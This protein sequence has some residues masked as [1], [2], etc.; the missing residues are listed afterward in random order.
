MKLISEIT[1][2]SIS[3]EILSEGTAPKKYKISGPFVH[4]EEINRNGRVYKKE[5]VQPEIDRYIREYVSARRALGELSHPDSPA[6]NP[7]ETSHL[8]TKLEF[9]DHLCMGEA[10]I[11]DTPNGKIIKSFIDGGVNFGVSTRG[12]GS[13]KESNGVKYVQSDFKLITVDVV[14]DPSG[15]DCYVEGMMEGKEWVYIEGHGWVE[16]YLEEAKSTLQKAKASDVEPLAL[17]IFENYL[18]RLTSRKIEF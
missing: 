12:L 7:K 5:F 11:L 1:T 2:E 17:Q 8:I 9:K 4:T 13:I 10:E 6:I 3:T 18:N 16:S 14:L 15:K